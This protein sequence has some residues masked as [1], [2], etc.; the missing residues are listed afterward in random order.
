MNLTHFINLFHTRTDIFATRWVKGNKSGYSPAILYDP[1]LYRSYN[2]KNNQQLKQYRTLN[3]VEIQ[4]HLSG[5]QH[6]GVYP[7][8]PNNTSAFIVADFD[9]GNWLSSA[10][11]FILRCSQVSIPA[12]LERSRSGNGG[13]VWIFFSQPYPAVKSRKLILHLLEE[14]GAVSRFD[15]NVSFDRLFPNQDVLSGKGFGNLIALPLHGESVKHG[16]CCFIDS[17]TG[18]AFEDQW[19]FI[20][21]I[22][23]VKVALLDRLIESKFNNVTRQ[24]YNQQ[25]N[26]N[27][28]VIRLSHQIE[29]LSNHLPIKLLTWIKEEL[30]FVNTEYLVKKKSGK[31]TFGT[32]RYYRLVEDTENGVIMPRGFI[33]RLIRYCKSEDIVFEFDDARNKFKEVRFAFSAAL[34]PYQNIALL[35]ALRKEMGIIIAPPGSGKTVLALKLIED[36]KQ[37]AVIIVHRQQLLTQWMERIEHFLGIPK[38]EIGIIGKGMKKFGKLITIATIQSLAKYLEANGNFH[39]GILIVDECHRI[40]A[41]TFRNTISKIETYYLYGL[42]ATPFRKYNDDKLIFAFLGD[43]ITEVKLE[44]TGKSK[45]AKIIIRNTNLDIPYNP[46]LD[47]FETLSKMIIHDTSRNKLIVDD[48]IREVKLGRRV[49]V[50]TERVDHINTLLQFLKQQYVVVTLCGEDS[51]KNR[52]VK[53]KQINEGNFQVLLTTGQFFGEGTDVKN[54]DTLFLVYPFSFKGKLIQYIGRIQRNETTPTVYDYRDIKIDYLNKL[55]L[56]RNSHYRKIQKQVSLFDDPDDNVTSK[57]S[58]EIDI[59]VKVPIMEL[60]FYQGYVGFHYE[61][62]EVKKVYEYTI[63]NDCFRPELD[64]LKEYFIKNMKSK[65]VEVHLIAEIEHEE[66]IS[67]QAVSD[68]LNKINRE[69]VEGLRFQFVERNFVKSNSLMEGDELKTFDSIK[70]LP[71]DENNFEASFI[72]QLASRN[73]KHSRHIQF[74]ASQHQSQILK[75]RFVLNPFAFVFLL[76]GQS[77]FHIVMETLDTEEATYIWHLKKETSELRNRIEEIGMQLTLIRNSGR[78]EFL[79]STPANFSRILHDYTVSEKSNSGFINWKGLLEERLV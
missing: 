79:N 49:I 16:N 66:L 18:I 35:E 61:I 60:N 68:D 33:G 27:E 51:E 12:Y 41:A 47:N 43:V 75:I 24:S 29:L 74:L 50:I 72:K 28:L 8:F 32:E 2:I 58:L 63:E 73:Y 10:K 67:Q 52:V 64:I 71:D 76:A 69:F 37:P 30:N 36:R 40:P 17:E 56:K 19:K 21:S 14:S 23:K 53:W 44:E 20:E 57:A 7:L 78:Q 59:R 3:E 26:K 77:L 22:Q 31:N 54:L 46:K 4:K 34:F 15:K 39:A 55:F 1:F 11:N 25:T 45:F 38:N 42:T 13:H 62:K 48:I 9:E 70:F 6:I 5:E 65:N